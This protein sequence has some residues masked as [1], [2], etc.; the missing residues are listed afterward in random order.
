MKNQLNSSDI[1]VSIYVQFSKPMKIQLIGG[2][3]HQI[4]LILTSATL[5]LVG[6][7][8]KNET[9]PVTDDYNLQKINGVNVKISKNDNGEKIER[10]RPGS[11]FHVAEEHYSPDTQRLTLDEL[12][13]KWNNHSFQEI[14]RK[15]IK[16]SSSDKNISQSIF[17]P[18]YNESVFNNRGISIYYQYQLDYQSSIALCHE[19][20]LLEKFFNQTKI[21]TNKLMVTAESLL[22]YNE[23]KNAHQGREFF[24]SRNSWQ[25]CIKVPVK[26]ITFSLPETANKNLVALKDELVNYDFKKLGISVPKWQIQFLGNFTQ[27]NKKFQIHYYSYIPLKGKIITGEQFSWKDSRQTIS[28]DKL[29]KSSTLPKAPYEIQSFLEVVPFKT[30]TEHQVHVPVIEQ[31]IEY[32]ESCHTF[33]PTPT[34]SRSCERG[35]VVKVDKGYKVITREDKIDYHK[36]HL[37]KLQQDTLENSFFDQDADTE[38][39]FPVNFD[40]AVSLKEFKSSLVTTV[41]EKSHQG[42]VT[43]KSTDSRPITLNHSYEIELIKKYDGW[44]NNRTWLE[45][46]P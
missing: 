19:A 18:M 26:T 40:T 28:F 39:Y 10:H 42:T 14:S 7:G 41:H 20:Q 25:F 5:F 8:K 34:R 9:G 1:K 35:I 17:L 21:H 6:C 13:A 3:M 37:P 16:I 36:T 27:N 29:F 22:T 33:V 43:L 15:E 31:R 38:F 11:V 23:L 30:T 4:L 32:P 45:I 24:E 2:S 12:S 44:T 46:L